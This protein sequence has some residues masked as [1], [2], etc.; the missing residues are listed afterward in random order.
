MK[1]IVAVL[2]LALVAGLAGGIYFWRWLDQPLSTP[3]Q[4][5]AAEFELRKGEAFAS[6]AGRLADRGILAYPRMW[7]TWARMTGQARLVK[8]GEYRLEAKDTPASLLARLVEGD[9]VTHQV[10]ILEGWTSMQAV[11]AAAAHG[12]LAHELKGVTVNT[13]LGALGLPAG[14]AEGL[15]FPDTYQFVRGDSDADILRRAYA[16][17]QLVLDE[18]WN[19]RATGLPYETPYQVL[20]AA[21]LI[22]KE[23]GREED[24]E[25][26]SQVFA[27]RLAR[28]M[29]L[30]TDPTVI[31]GLGDRFDGD[32]KRV[33]LREDTPY[34]TYVHRGLP[35]TPIA[36]PGSGSL[37]AAV[38]PEPG[39]YLFFVSRGDGTSQFSVSL[40]EHQQAVRRYQLQ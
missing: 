34:N 26:I 17:M 20:I 16:R 18:T 29:R 33:H 19:D 31:Y 6:L 21:S 25:F 30:Q 8:A 13:L 1:S 36:L 24:R 12:A 40:E 15:F 27:N 11:E 22:E 37:R 3:Q 14:H 28:N 4:A 35:P 32:L 5:E 9:V 2:M 10:R 38:H 39:D 23:T 7:A